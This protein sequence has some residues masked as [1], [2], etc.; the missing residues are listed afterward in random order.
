MRGARVPEPSLAALAARFGGEARA[1]PRENQP[2]GRI[3]PIALAG[4]GDL[5][6]LMHARFVKEARAALG[7]GAALVVERELLAKLQQDLK[8]DLDRDLDH[9][10]IWIVESAGVTLAD[11]L[12]V[13]D[14]DAAAPLVD[15][16]ARIGENVVLHPRV[17]IGKNVV[18]GANSV[19]GNPGFGW[20]VTAKG[21]RHV[22]QVGGVVIE[23]DVWIGAGCTIDAG[24]LSPTR[25]GAR[26]KIDA[27]VHV[28]HNVVI[29]E[30]CLVAAQCGFAGSAVIG[31][32]VQIGGQ[33]GI[34]DHVHV[35]SDAKIAGKSGVIGDV[36]EGAVVAGYPAVPRVRWLR[37][38]AR[39]HE[40][41]KT[42]S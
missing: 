26:T 9:A 29:G 1:N 34:G 15:G 38:V 24:T 20:A 18:I 12:E 35:G 36:P 22:P 27:Q 14:V 33:A 28:G 25:I 32:R 23:S 7:R 6:P 17:V 2:L 19:I 11:L 37:G 3:V 39:M 42:D 5:A 40:E 16:S 41:K 4:A 13:A 31:D 8:E 21:A 10:R 30:D